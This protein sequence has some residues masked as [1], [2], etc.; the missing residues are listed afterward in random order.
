MLRGPVDARPCRIDSFFHTVQA[1]LT[2]SNLDLLTPEQREWILREFGVL[3]AFHRGIA[4]VFRRYRE[5]F[6][7]LF[8][9]DAPVAPA[10]VPVFKLGWLLFLNAQ[11]SPADPL[12]RERSCDRVHKRSCMRAPKTGAACTPC[13]N[14]PRADTLMDRATY[15]SATAFLL[16]LSC[17]I[18]LAVQRD[19]PPL[20][21]DGTPTPKRC[22]GPSGS[23]VASVR[24]SQA[25]TKP[26]GAP[27]GPASPR[28]RAALQ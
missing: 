16:A 18:L 10:T 9:P 4:V 28:A 21:G 11:G 12:E 3:Q 19:A 17:L 13:H 1:F 20:R 6:V 15:S 8:G 5:A 2:E 25:R 24:A 22:G 23:D 27:Y 7:L 14:A 26:V